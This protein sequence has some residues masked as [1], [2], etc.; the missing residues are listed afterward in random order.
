MTNLVLRDYR[1]V[2]D[3][4]EIKPFDDSPISTTAPCL[5]VIDT[6]G[7][8]AYVFTPV[9]KTTEYVLYKESVS[10]VQHVRT[11]KENSKFLLCEVRDLLEENGI[12]ITN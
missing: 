9:G 10:G 5:I 1:D 2:T 3:G 11:P 7:S 8:M 6:D 4:K 12:T